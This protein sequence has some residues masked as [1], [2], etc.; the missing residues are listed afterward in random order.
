MSILFRLAH[1]HTICLYTLTF[2]H[3]HANVKKYSYYSCVEF[4]RAGTLTYQIITVHVVQGGTLLAHGGQ[5]AALQ[6]LR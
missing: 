2:I 4:L 1:I 5:R 3:F 6:R